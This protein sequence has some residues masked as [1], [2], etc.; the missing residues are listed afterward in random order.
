M[1]TGEEDQESLTLARYS[2]FCRRAL[3]PGWKCHAVSAPDWWYRVWRPISYC[4]GALPF[5]FELCLL[6]EMAGEAMETGVGS[7]CWLNTS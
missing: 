7:E 6:W 2:W 5:H 3:G 4:Q 1:V